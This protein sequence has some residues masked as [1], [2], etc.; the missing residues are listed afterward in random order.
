MR[1]LLLAGTA[2]AAEL[3]TRLADAGHD[4]IASL[5][6]ATREAGR[7]AGRV[8]RGGFGGAEGMEAFLRAEAVAALIDATHPFATAIAANA[9]RAAASADVPRL[10]LLRPPW[11]AE[12]GW[13]EVAD[14][15]AALDALPPGAR[16][17]CTTGARR[18]E[19]LGRRPDCALLLRAIEAPETLPPGVRLI[20]ARPPFP[21]EAETALMRRERITHLVTRNA[22]GAARARLDAARALG[23]PVLM[24]R[25]PPPPP[26][27]TV[28]T[29]AEALEWVAQIDA[30]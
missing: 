29:V 9:D 19:A 30:R 21:V 13:R 24:I 6:G 3:S 10:K 25:R 27:D 15:A 8:R 17:L 16:A 12:P 18:V 5:A 4:V 23:V 26:G 11:P 20:R 14:L 2:E 22:G 28:A 7:Y 1:V